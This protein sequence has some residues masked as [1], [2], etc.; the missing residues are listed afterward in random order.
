MD[1]GVGLEVLVKELNPDTPDIQPILLINILT[2][3]L[4]LMYD[5]LGL[6]LLYIW[7]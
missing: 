6:G 1:S 7:Y 2:E 5:V 4:F 3:Q